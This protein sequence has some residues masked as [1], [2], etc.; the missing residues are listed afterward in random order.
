MKTVFT[1]ALLSVATAAWAGP[2]A[3]PDSL[4]PGHPSISRPVDI[5]D[6]HVAKATGPNAK[7]V[8]EIVTQRTQL[9][10]KPVAV[11]GKVVKFHAA[12]MGKNWVHLRDGTGSQAQGSNDVLVTTQDQTRPGD[13]VTARG[14]V[15]INKDFGSGYAYPVLI[16]EAT[17]TP[18]KP[19]K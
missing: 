1:I 15:R 14:T 16:E 19:R 11:H 9:K 13:V 4:P 7:T 10:D 2:A 3:A 17:I 8:E 6:V 18:D 5:G 12:I